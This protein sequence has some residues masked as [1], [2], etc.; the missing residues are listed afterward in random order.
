MAGKKK[1]EEGF[2]HKLAQGVVD[3]IEGHA[4]KPADDQEQDEKL[5]PKHSDEKPSN[6]SDLSS[7]PKFQKF[8]KGD[9]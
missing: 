4:E 7:H 8:K 3:A 5:E 2:L 1:K 6:V 9:L